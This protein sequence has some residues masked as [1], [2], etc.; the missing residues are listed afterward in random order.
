MIKTSHTCIFTS[1]IINFVFLLRIGNRYKN[2]ITAENIRDRKKI[3]VAIVAS[4]LRF[5]ELI[6]L[7]KLDGAIELPTDLKKNVLS[8]VVGPNT[9][10]CTNH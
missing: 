6:T 7:K 5:D 1:V 3:Q 9:N 4:Y 2:K 10:A 8:S